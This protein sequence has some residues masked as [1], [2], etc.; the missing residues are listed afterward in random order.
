MPVCS[1]QSILGWHLEGRVFPELA[2]GIRTRFFGSQSQ[3]VYLTHTLSS[4]MRTSS[5]SIEQVKIT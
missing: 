1:L 2:S 5:L 4:L 3:H